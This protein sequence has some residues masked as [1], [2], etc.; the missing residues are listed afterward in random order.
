MPDKEIRSEHNPTFRVLLKLTRARGIKKHGLALFSGEKQVKEVLR[1]FPERCTA[2]LIPEGQKALPVSREKNIP[3]Y[4]LRADRFRELDLFDTGHALLVIR[5]APF[6]D[7]PLGRQSRGCTL[8]IPFQDPA[9]VGAVI[10][11]AAAFGVDRVVLLEE[12]AHP[13]LPK[14]G[15]A[16]GSALLRIPLFQGPSL[17][18]HQMDRVPL[19]TLSPRG[20][21][22][23]KFRFPSAFCLVPGLE[24]PGIPSHLEKAPSVAIPMAKGVESLNAALAT[25]IVLFHWKTGQKG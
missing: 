10:R 4:R 11:S 24:G 1:E 14:S 8:C 2:L 6:P 21:P 12:A 20:K 3:L 17:F 22:I 18:S 9:N 25:G 15:R 16:A 13:F 5:I 19:I 23:S 7:W